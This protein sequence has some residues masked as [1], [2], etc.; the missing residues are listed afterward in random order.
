MSGTE[1]RVERL[2][3]RSRRRGSGR[4]TGRREPIEHRP[5]PAPHTLREESTVTVEPQ[6]GDRRFDTIQAHAAEA[7]G[8]TRSRT[9]GRRTGAEAHHRKVDGRRPRDPGGRLGNE[10][11]GRNGSGRSDFTSPQGGVG[12]K[13]EATER[14]NQATNGRRGAGRSDAARLPTRS[15]PSQGGTPAGTPD[16]AR[17][18]SAPTTDP[19]ETWR[20]QTRYR[21][22]H[23]GS[24]ERRKPSRWWKTTRTERDRRSG[25]RRPKEIPRDLREWTFTGTSGDGPTARD[26]VPGE[27]GSRCAARRERIRLGSAR[28]PKARPR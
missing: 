16:T 11:T 12:A 7:S 4:G 25:I 27:A 23:A 6:P 3:E 15:K 19:E 2:L 14:S 13:P 22:Q 8:A 1:S 28:T 17:G 18:A 20:T 5:E 26:E 9:D 21:L 24:R 10:P